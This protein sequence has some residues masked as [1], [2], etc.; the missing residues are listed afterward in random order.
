MKTLTKLKTTS[1]SHFD[2]FST[3]QKSIDTI[4]N[5]YSLSLIKGSIIAF[6]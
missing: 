5:G 4:K 6:V 3:D 1:R 2:I